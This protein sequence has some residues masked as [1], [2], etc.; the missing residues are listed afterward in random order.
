MMTEEELKSALTDP[1]VFQL[2]IKDYDDIERAVKQCP[3]LADALL[4]RITKDPIEFKRLITSKAAF[5]KFSGIARHLSNLHDFNEEWASRFRRKAYEK[6]SKAELD[7]LDQLVKNREHL[8]SQGLPFPDHTQAIVD[9]ICADAQLFRSLMSTDQLIWHLRFNSQQ[10]TNPVITLMLSD[11][12][13]YEHIISDLSVFHLHHL[14]NAYPQHAEL[15]LA[16][17]LFNQQYFDA[18]ITK[19]H[20]L[21][22]LIINVGQ[23]IN[24]NAALAQAQHTRFTTHG[25][26]I[27]FFSSEKSLEIMVADR[28]TK[29]NVYPNYVDA[30]VKR[31]ITSNHYQEIMKTVKP[32]IRMAKL[33]QNS[34]NIK[35]LVI[36]LIFSSPEEFKRLVKSSKKL[37]TFATLHPNISI[38][39]LK[40]PD[41]V[42]HAIEAYTK[43]RDNAS[44][45]AQCARYAGN[46]FSMLNTH[47]FFKVIR[48]SIDRTHTDRETLN[49]VIKK[50]LDRPI[51]PKS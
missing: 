18:K 46:V 23:L 1:V 44:T 31:I 2:I 35:E 42:V 28:K 11:K 10:Y 3:A 20:E 5:N 30:L 13:V 15:F 40:T 6:K 48:R 29:N 8:T 22:A 34:F 37:E 26:S 19:S 32:L 50:E 4:V 49:A 21:E 24:P 51:T 14:N 17:F 27:S 36:P 33:F 39:R 47:L 12:A 7:S 16:P 25:N 43:A 38:F 41:E 9:L 45:V